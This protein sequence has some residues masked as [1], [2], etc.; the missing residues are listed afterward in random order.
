MALNAAASVP[1]DLVYL[2]VKTTWAHAEEIK[3]AAPYAN[4]LT[5]ENTMNFITP[6]HPG[7]FKYYQE[8][9][10]KIPQRLFPPK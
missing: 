1:D 8:K 3:K 2:L 10:L 6:L 7:A 9:G 5:Y 4:A